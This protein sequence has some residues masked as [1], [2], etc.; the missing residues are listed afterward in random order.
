MHGFDAGPELELPKLVLRGHLLKSSYNL[1]HP[2][3]SPWRSTHQPL[4][5]I[6]HERR[7]P[8]LACYTQRHF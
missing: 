8:R 2:F 7:F 4:T 1:G 6:H 3:R 5:S